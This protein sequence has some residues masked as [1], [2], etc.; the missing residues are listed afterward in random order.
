[1]KGGVLYLK[2]VSTGDFEGAL[3][4]LLGKDAGGLSASTIGRLKDTPF[5]II[6]K[7]NSEINAA[8][9]DPKLKARF[10][11]LGGTVLPGSAADFGKLIADDTEK[12]AKVIKFSGAKPE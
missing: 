4:A 9:V 8:L 12:W 3:V 10:A 11:D 6:G 2:G 5:E 7:L 1:M